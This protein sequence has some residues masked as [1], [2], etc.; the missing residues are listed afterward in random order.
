MVK[1]R[2]NISIEIHI[3]NFLKEEPELYEKI[4]DS[5]AAYSF[6]QIIIAALDSDG[7]FDAGY[8]HHKE[9]QEDIKYDKEL[10][11]NSPFGYDIQQ[12]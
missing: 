11:N 7:A 5:E 12:D 6:N 8:K 3:E 4:L 9:E 10:R 2:D 1:G